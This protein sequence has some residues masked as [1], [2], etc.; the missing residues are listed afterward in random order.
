M[1]NFTST[2]WNNEQGVI[3]AYLLAI[4][5]LKESGMGVFYFGHF[6]DSLIK[7]KTEIKLVTMHDLTDTMNILNIKAPEDAE[8]ETNFAFGDIQ[9]CLKDASV[10]VSKREVLA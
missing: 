3:K 7:N 5:T 9:L 4:E 6:L 8:K 2:E 1:L 10:I